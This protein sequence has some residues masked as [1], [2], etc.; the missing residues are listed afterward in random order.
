MTDFTLFRTTNVVNIPTGTVSTIP[1]AVYTTSD[2]GYIVDDS[3]KYGSKLLILTRQLPVV[4]GLPDRLY[5][6]T[7]KYTVLD[8]QLF[9]VAGRFFTTKKGRPAFA[10]SPDGPHVL[11]ADSFSCQ[12]GYTSRLDMIPEGDRLYFK[13]SLS[14]GG[15]AGDIYAV[16]PRDYKAVFD[17]DDI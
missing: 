3:G 7:D 12:R 11:V 10:I 2:G 8:T 4:S 13:R 5:F 9:G 16:L 14:N 15:G 6:F 1:A 17:I